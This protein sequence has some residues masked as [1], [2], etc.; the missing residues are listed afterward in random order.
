MFSAMPPP[1]TLVAISIDLILIAPA[2]A[3]S[4]NTTIHMTIGESASVRLLA[5]FGLRK[6]FHKVSAASRICLNSRD[7]E[8]RSKAGQRIKAAKR[9]WMLEKFCKIGAFSKIS[10]QRQ[11][12]IL[13][14]ELTDARCGRKRSMAS[15]LDYC[16]RRAR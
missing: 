2:K 12:P 3:S 4:A 7:R 11:A 16:T 14:M 15:Q 1:C 6:Q 5:H 9:H 10:S 13:R 8:K